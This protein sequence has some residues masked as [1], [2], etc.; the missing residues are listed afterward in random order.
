MTHDT[1][2][3]MTSFD[4]LND[5]LRIPEPRHPLTGILIVVGIAAWVAWTV[6]GA[7]TGPHM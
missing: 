3:A 4:R 1:G 7:I 2:M 5:W 6:V